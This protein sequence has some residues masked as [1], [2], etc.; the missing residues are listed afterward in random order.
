MDYIIGVNIG[1]T[2]EVAR[3]SEGARPNVWRHNRNSE[4]C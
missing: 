4:K 1:G 2:H 3:H